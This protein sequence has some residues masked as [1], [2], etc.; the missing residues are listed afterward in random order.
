MRLLLINTPINSHDIL[1]KFEKIYDD[2]KMIPIGISY[3]ASV[4]RENG[5]EV[6]ILDQYAECLSMDSIVERIKRFQPDIVGY[7]STTPNYY[8]AIGLLRKIRKIFPNVKTVMGGQHPSIFPEKV[9]EDPKVDF[10]IRDE[11]EYSLVALCKAIENNEDYSS[12]DGL[13]YK[14]ESGII[15]H[16]RPVSS[17]ALDD[18]PWPAYDLLP[19]HLYS[20]PSYT[21][22][23]MPVYQISA[24]RGCPN[25]CSYCINAELNIAARYR[26]RKINDVLDEIEMLIEKYGAKQ[27]QLWDPIFPLGKKH[28]F[29]FCDKLIERGLH[30]KI[31]WNSTT[32]AD[33]LTEEMLDAMAASGCKGLGF[34]IESGVTDLLKSVNKKTDLEKT[35]E[36]CR[37][38]TK[39]G[40]VVAGAF[41]L[42][43][44][45]ETEVMSKQTIEFAKSLDIHY[46]QFSIMVPYPGTPLY[47][48]LI[49][50]G[51][52]LSCGEDDYVRYNQSVG[53]TDLDPVYVPKGRTAD[54][55]K[56]SQKKAYTKF[57]FRPKLVWMHLPHLRIQLLGRMMKSLY[58]IIKLTIKE[59]TF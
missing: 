26:K 59:K 2:L 28:T 37:L 20:S 8:A 30:K 17:I 45:G 49:E 44:P 27:I 42:G 46:A 16:N 53:L 50:K 52:M 11:G 40:I 7:G 4:A 32:Y 36:I 33:L 41:I 29:E 1:G 22:F 21:R 48:N 18:L 14:S 57:Y 25:S 38:A 39:K 5:I 12:V 34:G 55:L 51:E 15:V 35:R 10:V 13:S 31:V 56:A 3:L 19:M 23:R 54:E 9:L 24:S 6:N 47:K 43:F 58:A